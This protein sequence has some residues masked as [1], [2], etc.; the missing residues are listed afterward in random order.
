MKEGGH[1][2]TTRFRRRARLAAGLVGAGMAIE[3]ASL[4]WAHPL[5]FL[6][7]TLVGASLVV[8]GACLYLW[9]EAS[10]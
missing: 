6:A 9:A 8:A 4:P 2:E 7:T 5:A 1:G 3:A 10:R